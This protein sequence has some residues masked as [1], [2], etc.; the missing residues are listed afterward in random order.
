MEQTRSYCLFGKRDLDGFLWIA[1]VT[2]NRLGDALNIE[3]VHEQLFFIEGDRVFKNIGY[4]EKGKLFS[5]EEFGKPINTLEDISKNG[6]WLVLALVCP[7]WAFDFWPDPRSV[8]LSCT[9]ATK[10]LRI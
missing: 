2:N 5:E 7:A 6:Y 1:P 9:A 3:F 10:S 4:S 8:I